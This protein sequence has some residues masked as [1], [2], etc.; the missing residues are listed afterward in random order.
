MAVDAK[1]IQ[2]CVLRIVKFS[3]DICSKFVIKHPLISCV[4]VLLLIFYFFLP[5]AFFLLIYSCPFIACT[6]VFIKFYQHSQRKNSEKKSDSGSGPPKLV[7][8]DGKSVRR[9]HTRSSSSRSMEVKSR[10]AVS[11]EGTSKI[12]DE[13]RD[14]TMAGEE[15]IGSLIASAC[16]KIGELKSDLKSKSDF[17]G[18]VETEIS[19]SED[20][21]AKESRN[22]AVEWNED[23]QKNLMDLG[24]SELERNK[25]LESLI[26]RRRARKL[27]K[28]QTD[29]NLMSSINSSN[30]FLVAPVSIAR[31]NTF[32]VHSAPDLLIPGSAPSILL[33]RNP[34]DLPY[35]PFEEK[36]NLMVDSFQQEFMEAQQKE[37]MFCR[38]ES[39]A[40]GSFYRFHNERD[41]AGQSGLKRR[42]DKGVSDRVV[43]PIQ[44]EVGG[45]L[46]HSLSATDLVTEN[47]ENSVLES[48][49]EELEEA[50]SSTIENKGKMIE[51][52]EMESSINDGNEAQIM[53][54]AKNESSSSLPQ[55]QQVARAKSANLTHLTTP[56]FRF[57]ES[58]VPS[59]GPCPLP[60]ARTPNEINYLASP[61]TIDRSTLE[62]HLLYTNSGP[63]H[64][65]NDSI[66][67]D[68]QVEVSE[69]GSPPLTG[70]GS[71]S[72]NDG[73]SL[74]YDGDAE[75]EI[76]SGSDEM[77][78][79]SP[80]G[81]KGEEHGLISKE[82]NDLSNDNILS[83]FSVL[84]TGP[85]GLVIQSPQQHAHSLDSDLNMTTVGSNELQDSLERS[86]VL[87]SSHYLQES[88]N[89]S[90]KSEDEVIIIDNLDIPD[91]LEDEKS[92][93]VTCDLPETS[94]MS[95]N[96]CDV[97]SSP[98]NPI[99]EVTIGYITDTLAPT[100][101]DKSVQVTFDLPET[102]RMSKIDQEVASDMIYESSN[103]VERKPLSSEHPVEEVTISYSTYVPTSVNDLED[104]KSVEVCVPETSVSEVLH[105][106]SEPVDKI[107]SESSHHIESKSLNI[108]APV[109]VYDDSGDRQSVE[110]TSDLPVTS[111]ISEIA[112]DLTAVADEINSGV[113]N[114]TE[115]ES[116]NT[117]NKA[118]K[119]VSITDT[120]DDLR[121][122][123]SVEVGNDVPHTQAIEDRAVPTIETEQSIIE[124]ENSSEGKESSISSQDVKNEHHTSQV[125]TSWISQNPNNSS[126]SGS[127]VA[128]VSSSE[129]IQPPITSLDLN[130]HMKTGVPDSD[131]EDNLQGDKLLDQKLPKNPA[132]TY[133]QNEQH[134]L[135]V[136]SSDH[137]SIECVSPS[138]KEASDALE[139]AIHNAGEMF[140][141]NEGTLGN[142]SEY[143]PNIQ[144]TNQDEEQG[145]LENL[146]E[147]KNTTS[148]SKPTVECDHILMSSTVGDKIL[149]QTSTATNETVSDEVNNK[150]R[151]GLISQ[152][153]GEP[154]G[155]DISSDANTTEI[156]KL[157][158]DQ[159]HSLESLKDTKFESRNVPE[160]AVDANKSDQSWGN[161]N[162]NDIKNAEAPQD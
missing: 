83:D 146:T 14:L 121:V 113:S 148:P 51:N 40:L 32:D 69:V 64:T 129:K 108:D 24:L 10:E 8:K 56:P 153:E 60:R 86:S 81:N 127:T 75:K 125:D 19:T 98:V 143:D 46:H 138:T 61:A 26:A 20:E 18:K 67:S 74:T 54:E 141:T 65:P 22:K 115:S 155:I 147:H 44:L 88:M 157:T 62:N 31:S 102:S 136:D 25:R 7:K 41:I 116:L 131:K 28:A 151:I 112:R 107:N 9:T 132:L 96:D 111:I 29:K 76:T 114:R 50:R 58:P 39:F 2:V 139:S 161:K 150:D 12:L 37:M 152:N 73:D 49:P 105:D 106:L 4:F 134:E 159:D 52:S 43:Q 101:D 120:L 90:E 63:W 15:K 55:N 99:N 135:V 85:E 162:S 144:P 95:E 77:W 38:H 3:L 36:P 79:V 149:L 109:Q 82:A 16:E 123:T 66:A 124:D 140:H 30:Q 27:Y 122:Q 48:Q 1:R 92:I 80:R 119:D 70:D 78:G 156:P 21:E 145:P 93:K 137:S 84:Q 11:E 57:P 53:M 45:R 71:A 87:D 59:S 91:E 100:L 142:Q 133:T 17:S 154:R 34:F 5:K 110:V 6:Y 68:M 35:D 42:E 104:L 126:T 13:G 103:H 47:V 130:L 158:D 160:D 23:D 33:Q 117:L 72:S 97:K 128:Q 118:I 94:T 89:A